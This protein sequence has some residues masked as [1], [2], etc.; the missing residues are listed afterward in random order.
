MPC[1]IYLH[2]NSSSRLEALPC[3]DVLLP[4]NMT[5]LCFDFA[6]CG[7]SEG[8]Y[9]SLGWYEREDLETVIDY[10]RKCNKISTIG[11]WGRSMGAA[12]A[13][14]HANQ[15]PSIA[16][17]VL[18][19]AFTDLKTLAE[20]LCKQYA[21][22]PKLVVSGAMS[23]VR[24]TIQSKAKFDINT[25]CPIN[26]VKNAYIPAFFVHGK[27][28]DFVKPH[29]TQKLYDEYSGDKNLKIVEGDHNAPRP[30]FLLDS[31]GIFFY[32]TMQVKF[33]VPENNANSNEPGVKN[34]SEN[35]HG[36][37]ESHDNLGLGFQ[38]NAYNNISYKKIG[39][40]EQIEMLMG[41][42][43]D[44]ELKKAIEESLKISD[45]YNKEKEKENKEKSEKVEKKKSFEEKK[46][47]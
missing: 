7:L 16:G 21:S 27:D 10:L 14:M 11:L 43:D 37:E 28:D 29:H 22:I 19:S 45:E 33:L 17:L 1:V 6:G 26:H 12:T 15:D 36:F 18:D 4:A 32:N 47:N 41:D 44:E 46:M 2:G 31:I 3:I 23:I 13:L 5:L 35:F 30:T 38:R 9:I 40:E 42:F 20:E 34:N 24:K 8:E 25:L 39:N